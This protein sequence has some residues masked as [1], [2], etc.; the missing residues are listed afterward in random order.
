MSFA[1]DFYPLSEEWKDFEK[2]IGGIPPLDL[3]DA[4]SA[5]IELRK[6]N[7]QG[8]ALAPPLSEKYSAKTQSITHN[9]FT[10]DVKIY[11]PDPEK[12]GK[13]PHPLIVYFH[14]GGFML[15]DLDTEE[16]HCASL[17]V[18]H[19]VVL[20]SVNYYHSPEHPYPA[21]VD[22]AY[23][24]FEWAV[25]NAASLGA[26]SNMVITYGSS[27]GGNLATVVAIRDKDSG[28]NRVKGQYVGIPA[29]CH[30]EGVPAELKEKMTS[31]N[32]N[33]DAPILN[34]LSMDTFLR[35]I[36]DGALNLIIMI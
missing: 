17:V 30:P 4:A 3:R 11:H 9:G 7:A 32:T 6:R 20:V 31:F 14:G 29:T 13:E 21:P 19:H 1:P 24:G 10:M 8:S 28:K 35:K 36:I 16:L 5:R 15:G 18:T 12:A 22:S 2:S 33:K 34:Q 26:D 27:A 23:A 25:E